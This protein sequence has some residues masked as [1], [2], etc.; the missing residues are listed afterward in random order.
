MASTASALLKLENQANGE[1][2]ST[3]GDKADTNF[4]LV[5]QAIAGMTSVTVTTAD[6][7]LTDTQYVENEARKMILKASGA[8]TAARSII[9]PT[10]TKLYVVHNICTGGFDL[11]VKTS[12]GTGVVVP[13]NG[14]SIVY[15]D[16]TNVV[17]V[18]KSGLR[19]VLSKTGAYTITVADIDALI[20][21]SASGGAFSITTPAAA[22]A[23]AG[24]GFLVQKTDSSTNAVTI[25]GNSSETV[26]GAATLAL[27]KQWAWAFVFTDGSN[28]FA[29]SF[30]AGADLAWTGEHTFT[31]KVNLD[32]PLA[33]GPG[34][35]L[36][37][38]SGSI[39][40]TGNEHRI[41]TQSSAS[42]DDL[43]DIDDANLED[44]A[45]LLLRAENTARTVVVKNGSGNHKI[46]LAGDLDFSIDDDEKSILLRL[47][48]GEWF[49]VCR[50]SSPLAAASQS[51]MEAAS[52]TAVAVTPGR[53]KYGPGVAKA[54]VRFGGASV[55]VAD[56]HGV[57]S[58]TD[59]GVGQYRVNLSVTMANA[60]YPIAIYGD[61]D[62]CTWGG[63][64]QATSITTTTI[65]LS[66]CIR[67]NDNTAQDVN[68]CGVVAFGDQS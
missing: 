18:L 1:N 39:T 55:T 63:P 27:K 29:F 60:N 45:L 66:A 6:V 34:T 4:E 44:G 10:R 15:C 22:T 30:D 36:T 65:Q 57:S 68:T 7:T 5:E 49:E 2:D 17:E 31:G 8:M 62:R 47:K 12:A 9:V 43:T 33:L 58:M 41:D 20:K 61:A 54:W 67:F 13:A 40:P 52:S 59:Q 38:S 16:G 32:G 42:T 23:G 51:E 14:K 37:I 11:T 48:G 46:N 3:W 24:F 50:S 19:T 21:A 35:E 56:S 26:N 28:W 25:D 64:A 53:Q